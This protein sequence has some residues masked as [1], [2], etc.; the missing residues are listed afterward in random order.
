MDPE[1]DLG[2]VI[3]DVEDHQAAGEGVRGGVGYGENSK[4]APG[5]SG[6]DDASD[7]LLH[8]RLGVPEFGE[9]CVAADVRVGGA[10]GVGRGVRLAHR[11]QPRC[12][13][14]AGQWE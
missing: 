3:G 9:V 1:A 10:V 8:R 7:Y 13:R 14:G 11:T 5:Q 6:F 4:I 12:R 2:R